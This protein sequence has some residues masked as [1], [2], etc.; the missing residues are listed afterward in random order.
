MW[1][2]A[3]ISSRFSLVWLW[4][5]GHTEVGRVGLHGTEWVT[6]GDLER[7]CNEAVQSGGRETCYPQETQKLLFFFSTKVTK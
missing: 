6:S 3:P 4:C 1:G 5:G 2:G 7:G